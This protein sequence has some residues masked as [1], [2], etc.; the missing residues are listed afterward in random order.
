MRRVLG[1]M[2]PGTR[3]PRLGHSTYEY[4]KEAFA[5]Q[6]GGLIEEGV[7]FSS[8]P[9]KPAADDCAGVPG[10]AVTCGREGPVGLPSIV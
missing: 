3:L 4:L 6:S 7:R 8:K 5:L 10:P 1:S 9:A 2:G